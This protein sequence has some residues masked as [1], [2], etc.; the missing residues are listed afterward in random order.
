MFKVFASSIIAFSL[1]G[2]ATTSVA[3]PLPMDN[4]P[5]DA[6]KFARAMDLRNITD[7][8]DNYLVYNTMAGNGMVY[9]LKEPVHA[10]EKGSLQ[11]SNHAMADVAIGFFVHDP[12][13][14]GISFLTS[15]RAQPVTDG[16]PRIATWSNTPREQE[17]MSLRNAVSSSLA[18][19]KGYSESKICSPDKSSAVLS[20][21]TKRLST[22]GE[23]IEIDVGALPKPPIAKNGE[24][25]VYELN[26]CFFGLTTLSV[27][28]DKVKELSS[29]LGPQA[30]VFIPG[31]GQH[32]PLVFSNGR[33]YQFH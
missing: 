12:V 25:K 4:N 31:S 21:V 8:G 32:P 33:E 24:L 13:I 5:S 6:L 2:C 26:P 9:R 11:G 28:L 27:N 23:F 20:S 29:T 14:P 15:R 10:N 1:M 18:G 16:M 19:Y 17:V 3:P 7:A 30:A 22:N